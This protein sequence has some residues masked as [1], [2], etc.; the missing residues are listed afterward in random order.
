MATSR[1]RAITVLLFILGI[2]LLAALACTSDSP[3][4]LIPR[5]ATPSPTATNPP[6]AEGA[7]TAFDIGDGATVTGAFQVWLT[8]SPEPDARS[9]RVMAP[10]YQGTNVE[11]LEIATGSDGLVY[12]QVDCGTGAG[13]GWTTEDFLIPR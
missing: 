8:R 9:N 11:V 12:Y 10:C 6:L 4:W 5:T 1:K 3:E 2:L 7:E 13:A